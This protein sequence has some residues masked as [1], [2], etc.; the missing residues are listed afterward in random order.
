MKQANEHFERFVIAR[1]E[2]DA[3]DE[4]TIIGAPESF[5]D[6]EYF[7]LCFDV[8]ISIAHEFLP[9]DSRWW[10]V[11]SSD[12]PF[13]KIKIYPDKTSGITA[14]F[15]HQNMN[16]HGKE[17]LPWSEGEICVRQPEGFLG[18][19]ISSHDPIGY[20]HRLRWYVERAVIWCNAAS[21]NQLSIEGLP[22]EL[23]DFSSG[24]RHIGFIETKQSLEFWNQCQD[25]SGLAICEVQESNLSLAV[26][27]FLSI[28]GATVFKPEWGSVSEQDHDG[29][30]GIWVRLP[31]MPIIGPY[32]A[33]STYQ[34]LR[35]CFEL[36]G[37]SFESVIRPLIHALKSKSRIL[38]LIGFPIPFVEGGEQVRM[39]WQ[40]ILLPKLSNPT[41]QP[42]GFRH[43]V[44]HDLKTTLVGNK[45]IEWQSSRNWDFDER[46]SR[47]I[48]EAGFPF[49][50]I[51]IIG[52]GS[53]G[54]P[55]A[56][57]LSRGS[58]CDLDII[59]PEPFEIGNM[60]RHSLTSSDIG[61]TKSDAL[62]RH[63][64]K[65]NPNA[66]VRSFSE[67]FTRLSQYNLADRD[68][69]IDCTAED[70]VLRAFS[71]TEFGE[72]TVVASVSIGYKAK[73]LYIYTSIGKRFSFAN[74]SKEI[75]P[76][77][78][79]EQEETSLDDFPWD[80][81]GC[82]HPVFPAN[83]SDVCLLSAVAVQSIL[84]QKPT[85]TGAL[86]VFEQTSSGEV[87]LI[88]ESTDEH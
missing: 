75:N 45:P 48:L 37:L 72:S 33:P 86:R 22:F 77:M 5:C 82:W 70:D 56:E 81:V 34:E 36:C 38:L 10:L 9:L 18:R 74:F 21:S 40:P 7:G 67:R 46:S 58:K 53:V 57:I 52:V 59:D 43:P 50:K 17:L 61:S 35:Q 26:R 68:L 29:L 60:I 73:R 79:L 69:V 41:M 62:A 8:R 6:G 78:E 55:V 13:G 3:V 83:V 76:W 19:E 12:F 2:I 1:R 32:G 30:K 11:A 42:K 85:C 14:T 31:F 15:R 4:V 71:T 80:A 88:K 84:S 49:Q 25:H 63:L 27:S 23:P 16:R 39:H 20:E 28:S 66:I 44:D 87:R 47:G 24:P 65:S 51:T 54:A 64:E